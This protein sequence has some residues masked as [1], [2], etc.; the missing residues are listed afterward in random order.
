[1]GPAS[2]VNLGGGSTGSAAL[3]VN[4]VS[5]HIGELLQI[6]DKNNSNRMQIHNS[7]GLVDFTGK[8]Q[9][10]HT[11]GFSAPK[12]DTTDGTRFLQLSVSS[13]Y[14]SIN[15][16]ASASGSGQELRF[17]QGLSG[18]QLTIRYNQIQAHESL[19]LDGATTTSISTPNIEST[20]S[21]DTS[22]TTQYHIIFTKSNGTVNGKITTNAFS[23]TYSTTSDYR[24]K[25]NIQAVSGATNKVLSLNPVN[26]RWKN[27]SL[28][29]DGFLAH[30]VGL[31]VPEAVVGEKDAIDSEGNPDY[32][33]IDQAK[34]VPLLVK[35]IQELEA[36]ITALENP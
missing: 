16:M 25:E 29:Q 31:I 27:S 15:S 14:N 17:T 32:Q 19:L 23:T 35:T 5:G 2:L 34:L 22:G 11:S 13:G 10:S 30:E 1:M 12:F 26:F 20:A 6:I 24:L 4:A 36:R 28:V 8:V 7:T 18:T 9:T 3:Y 21:S 33:S